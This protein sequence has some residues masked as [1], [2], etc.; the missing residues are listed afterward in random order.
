MD[1][2]S[3]RKYA[4][5]NNLVLPKCMRKVAWSLMI[6][7]MPR[8]VARSIQSRLGELKISKARYEDLLG[9]TDHYYPEYLKLLSTQVLGWKIC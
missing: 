2:N 8:E 3:I 6:C 4:R 7:A 9:E 1:R 5:R